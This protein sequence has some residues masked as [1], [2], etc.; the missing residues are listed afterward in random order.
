MTEENPR[1]DLRAAR[2]GWSADPPVVLVAD[3]DDAEFNRTCLAM[4]QAH[5]Q[6]AVRHV[7]TGKQLVS[8]LR[9]ENAF[10]DARTSPTPAMIL[11]DLGLPDGSAREALREIRTDP[12]LRRIPVVVLTRSAAD[13]DMARAYE[14]GVKSF[15]H[16]T[17]SFQSMVQ[18][19]SALGR[20]W[21]EIIE[22]APPHPIASHRISH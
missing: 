19:L 13:G 10:A 17:L 1:T 2:I 3:G 6:N 12:A 22:S 14:L 7:R 18:S 21:L 4:T 20:C 11:L 15:I 5:I 9:R 16:K 8:Y